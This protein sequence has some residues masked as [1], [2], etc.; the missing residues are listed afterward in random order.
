MTIAPIATPTLLDWSQVRSGIQAFQRSLGLAEESRAFLY[1]ALSKILK[2]DDDE[3]RTAI[4]DG[5]DDR[6][7][8]AVYVDSRPERRVI[9]LFQFKHVSSFEKVGSSFPSN[10]ID[11]IQSFLE[12]F[13][14]KDASLEKTCNP[15]LWNKVQD[16]WE[17]LE[18]AVYSIQIHL[19]NNA[20]ALIP[21]H[22]SRFEEALRPYQHALVTQHD[23]I[24]FSRHLSK[25]APVDRE[26]QLG[27]VEDQYFGR[28]DGFAKGL[29]GT[30]R[31]DEIVR[32]ITDQNFPQEVDDTLFEDNIR[33]Y[34]GEE[35]EINRKILTTALS[36]VNTQFWYLNN[37]I[38]IVCDRMEYQPRAANP[39]VRMINP[40][41]VNGGQTSHA[42]FEAARSDIASIYDVKL[43]LRIIET[44]DRTFTNSVAEAT[45]SQTP[46][47]SRDIR[48]N[49]SIQI[50]I[51][52]ALVGHGY[53][54]ERKN[55]QHIEQPAESRID[56]VKLGQIILA[57]VLRE[58]D[59]AKTSSN[60]IFGEYYGWV[61]DEAILSA[62]NI[63]AMWRVYRMVDDDRRRALAALNSRLKK[64]YDESWII[65]GVYHILYMLSLTCEREGTSLYD[66]AGVEKHYTSVKAQ[67]D[68]FM[69]QNRGQA[70]YRVFRSA[71][72]KQLLARFARGHQLE[73]GLEAPTP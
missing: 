12:C 10:E 29:I 28:T 14:R 30:V 6:G 36:D 66:F 67:I 33:L 45:N 62:E 49:D 15:L 46:I 54:Y 8:D 73:L 38:T 18:E 27:L 39:K 13:L 16:L 72:T 47:R 61:F 34:L 64:T 44:G 21:S 65:E 26:F 2:I 60:R 37:G 70:A 50:R 9:H 40:Q 59:R 53:F 22:L 11:K 7:I 42:L 56:A 51:E 58:P 32:L 1:F 4:T 24:W 41:I 71:M 63:I 19:C 48:S 69:A 35:N 55:D 17:A 68:D 52:N 23:L 5:G 57:Y 20:T 43:L 25:G 3:I 31:G